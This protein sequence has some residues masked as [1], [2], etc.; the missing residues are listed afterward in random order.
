MKKVG[1]PGA[2]IK[3]VRNGHTE[4]E[5]YI[6]HMQRSGI[7]RI[8]FR[9]DL[10]NGYQATSPGGNP[11]Q[12]ENLAAL[13]PPK[14]VRMTKREILVLEGPADKAIIQKPVWN[15]FR[16]ARGKGR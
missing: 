10:P 2:C 11:I 7:Y 9:E 14:G 8:E 5:I 12:L 13:H 6:F 1:A 15:R 16:F 4:K 3:I